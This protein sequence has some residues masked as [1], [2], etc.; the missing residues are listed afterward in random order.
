M[1]LSAERTS[2]TRSCCRNRINE[3]PIVVHVFHVQSGLTL[4][5]LRRTVAKTLREAGLDEHTI[6]DAFGQ[7]TKAVVRYYS[8][9]ADLKRK[10]KGI[11]TIFEREVNTRRT[12]TVKPDPEKLSNRNA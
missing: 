1:T 3:A 10:M 5:G 12:A 6:T 9:S 7:K 2:N 4:Y 11:G 8:K